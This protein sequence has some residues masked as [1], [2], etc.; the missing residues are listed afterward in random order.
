MGYNR[1]H[2]IVV[3]GMEL[4][5]GMAFITRG[6]PTI[7]E[8]HAQAKAIFGTEQVSELLP[9]AFNHW[10]SFFIAPDGSKEGWE[11]SLAGDG[12][13]EDFVN[14]LRDKTAFGDGSPSCEWVEVQYGDDDWETKV[15]RDSDEARRVRHGDG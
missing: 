8:V 14:Y 10:R 12:R 9:A 2:A 7:Q 15:V 1:H 6:I 4:P 13:R 5:E 11:E 3:T